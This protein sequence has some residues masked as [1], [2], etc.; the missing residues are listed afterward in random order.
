MSIGSVNNTYSRDS[1]GVSWGTLPITGWNTLKVNP[2]HDLIKVWEG[3]GGDVTY[4]KNARKGVM[5]EVTFSQ[6]HATSRALAALVATWEL[7]DAPIIVTDFVIYDKSG[8]SVQTY[9]NT[10]LVKGTGVE[11]DA[12]P[13]EHT[14]TFHSA[15][16]VYTP[17]PPGV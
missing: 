5:I 14:W 9:G 17:T 11:Y 13:G 3:S 8:S 6:T 10:A 7:S 16:G 2:Q 1:V 12:E 4:S 15:K